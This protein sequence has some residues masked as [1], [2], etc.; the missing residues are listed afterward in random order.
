ML[1]LDS[2][3]DG[4]K[5]TDGSGYRKALLKA[6]TGRGAKVTF[7]GSLKSGPEPNNEHEGHPGWAIDRISDA[8]TSFLDHTPND[9]K[10]NIILLHAGTNDMVLK[11]H[12]ATDR[13][14][15]LINWL[16][17]KAPQ[18]FI[19]VAEIIP[20]KDAEFEQRVQAY[21]TGLRNMFKEN[22]LRYK[23]TKV[24]LLN[25]H[26]AVNVATLD[27]GIHPNDE[28]YKQMADAWY[29]KLVELARDGKI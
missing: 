7:M 17:I 23:D 22:P 13:L 10:P 6:L 16:R 20:F 21:N 12:D 18:A 29:T 8:A 27:D 24:Q 25:M 14:G 2:I 26:D 1:I 19:V 5:S 15:R 28:G 3:T 4:F 9:Q 11:H